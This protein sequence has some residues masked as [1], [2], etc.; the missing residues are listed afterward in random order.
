MGFNVRFENLQLFKERQVDLIIEKNLAIAEKQKE[1]QR[2]EK[3]FKIKT[4]IL[5]EPDKMLQ[6]DENQIAVE[7]YLT[8]EQ[9]VA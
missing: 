1:L 8:R 4:H 3:L 7:K 6:V 9:R 5:E 2:P